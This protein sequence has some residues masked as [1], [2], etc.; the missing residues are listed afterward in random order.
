MDTKHAPGA[1]PGGEHEGNGYETRDAN[2][3]SLLRF[4]A[5]LV[6]TLVVAGTVSL[7]VYG[8]LGKRDDLGP[9]ATPFERSRP[10]PPLPQLQVHPVEDL[11][12]YRADQEKSLDSYGW[13][14]RSR[15]TVHIPIERAMDL[16]L[17]RG[18]LPARQGTATQPSKAGTPTAGGEQG[19]GN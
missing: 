8:Y 15:G 19:S 17:Q 5:V 1:A 12:T 13:V 9:P 2:P 11:Q 16:L 4:G 7:W 10:L 6:V 3:A 18:G 14:D